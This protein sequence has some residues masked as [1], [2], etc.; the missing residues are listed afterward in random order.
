M[1]EIIYRSLMLNTFYPFIKSPSECGGLC[2]TQ[3]A[4]QIIF[5]TEF[6][7]SWNPQIRD[8]YLFY[9]APSLLFCFFST[10]E[11]LQTFNHFY[12]AEVWAELPAI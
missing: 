5:N 8:K 3:L 9:S 11:P 4:A 1:Q 7:A 12:S 10:V 2:S 6:L